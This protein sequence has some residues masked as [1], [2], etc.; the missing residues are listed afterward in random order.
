MYVEKK[1][2]ISIPRG[3]YLYQCGS[4]N[5]SPPFSRRQSA[6][7][8]ASVTSGAATYVVIHISHTTPRLQKYRP[9]QIT[10]SLKYRQEVFSF[11]LIPQRGG[12]LH[13]SNLLASFFLRFIDIAGS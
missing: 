12:N 13:L 1:L 11:R 3:V 6:F 4:L 9:N 7:P 10:G 2:H 8:L 5:E